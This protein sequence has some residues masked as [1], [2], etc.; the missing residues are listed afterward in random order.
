VH[1]T[2]GG[3]RC[4]KPQDSAPGVV[5]HSL[6]SPRNCQSWLRLSGTT[7]ATR[8]PRGLHGGQRRQVLK[9]LGTSEASG[10][11][12]SA[13]NR[14][15]GGGSAGGQALAWGQR[16]EGGRRRALQLVPPG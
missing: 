15:G 13:E 11:H 7:D 10:C 9:L 4:E 2:L 14:V 5:R 16:K 8:V 12:R 1:P 3:H 6:R